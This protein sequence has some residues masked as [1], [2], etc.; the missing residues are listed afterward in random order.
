MAACRVMTPNRETNE[1]I[2]SAEPA[3]RA[4]LINEIDRGL[5]DLA[6]G[7]IRAFDVAEICR[8]GRELRA[9]RDR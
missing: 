7:R 2:E 3:E 9:A 8:R 5:A 6:A 4:L 1:M